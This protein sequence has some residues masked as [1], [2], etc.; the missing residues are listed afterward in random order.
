[1]DLCRMIHGQTRNSVHYLYSH[2][3]GQNITT[4][5]PPRNKVG[6]QWCFAAWQWSRVGSKYYQS[7][8]QRSF[9]F[10]YTFVLEP[11]NM[12][13]WFSCCLYL[14]LECGLTVGLYWVQQWMILRHTVTVTESKTWAQSSVKWQYRWAVFSFNSIAG[15]LELWLVSLVSLLLEGQNSDSHFC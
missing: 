6:L 2:S 15:G 8:P 7:Q 9:C 13:E 10:I 14:N 11:F 3:I 12:S 5:S 1:M 4:M